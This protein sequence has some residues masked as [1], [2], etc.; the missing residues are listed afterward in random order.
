MS[1]AFASVPV[2]VRNLG[3]E[4]VGHTY[5]DRAIAL[6]S[7][8]DARIVEA[9]ESRI[10]RSA[11]GVVLRFPKVIELLRYIMVPF[12]DREEFFSAK[13]V[14][15]RDKFTCGYCGT[16]KGTMTWDHIH[17]KSRGGQDTWTNSITACQRC[18]SEKGNMTLEEWAVWREANKLVPRTLLFEPTVPMKRYF[19]T[20]KRPGE[21]RKKSAFV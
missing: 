13:G 17:P 2:Q 21:K 18:N 16:K 6:V 4:P 19:K 5:L 14:L 7:R 1:V 15:R 12:I 20:N 3:G 11:A 9:D 8:G 10:V